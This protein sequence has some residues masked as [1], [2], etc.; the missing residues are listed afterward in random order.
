MITLH[1]YGPAFWHDDGRIIGNREGLEALKRAI[2]VALDEG[3]AQ[4][5]AYI[6][7]GKGYDFFVN[8]TEDMD[9]TPPP[10]SDPSF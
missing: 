6:A 3:S 10:Y 9:D 2:E 5:E 7:D 4:I 8:L 1:L